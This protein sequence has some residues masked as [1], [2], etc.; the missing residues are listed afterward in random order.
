V[1]AAGAPPDD[2][3]LRAPRN[4]LR[5]AVSGS[6]W[7]SAWFLMVYVF[8]TGWVLCAAGFTAAVAAA[9]CAVTIA[10]IP[11]LVAAAGVLRGCADAERA[12]LSGVL[13]QPVRGEYRPVTGKGLIAQ[14]ST[15]WKDRATWRDLT[16]VVGLWVPLMILDTVVLTVWLVFLAGI[17]TP[18]WYRFPRNTF[19]HGQVVH[20]IQLGYFPNGPHAAGRWGVYVHSL[21]TALSTAAVCLVLFLLFNYV[22]VATAR[23]HARIA[24]A[25]LGP[26]A[27]P[28]AAAKDVLAHPGP[29][30]SLTP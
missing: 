20:G 15:R 2:F 9:I 12:R 21:P 6:L 5:L 19:A 16:Y 7:R 4:P 18:V 11:L 8:A 28:L 26:V 1:T 13:A 3:R 14:A 10:G 17:T 27:D 25:V 24:R 29:L 30:Q 22:V 23:A